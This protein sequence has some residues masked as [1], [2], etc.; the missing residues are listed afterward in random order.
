MH[1]FIF[2]QTALPMDLG[3]A[4][5]TKGKPGGTKNQ[6]HPSPLAFKSTFFFCRSR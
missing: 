5:R 4:F 6:D 2:D 3:F 1:A